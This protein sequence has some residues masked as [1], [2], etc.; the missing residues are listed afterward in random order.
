M[1]VRASIRSVAPRTSIV[2]PRASIAVARA[3][4]RTVDAELGRAARPTFSDS[5]SLNA[6]DHALAG[7][8][9]DHLRAALGVDPPELALHVA[10]R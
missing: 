7:V 3:P 2:T 4:S 8:E 10:A 5:F 1:T 9:Q 6:D